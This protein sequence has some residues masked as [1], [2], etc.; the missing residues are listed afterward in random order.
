MQYILIVDKQSRLNP[1]NEKKSYVLN[2]EE[3]RTNGSVSDELIISPD[4][5]YVMRKLKLSEYQVL[6]VLENPI[7]EVIENPQIELFEGDNYIYLVDTVGN[8]FYAEYLIKND[9][10]DTF[11]TKREAKS[12][13]DMASN[14]VV[15]SVNEKLQSYSTTEEMNAAIEV[16]S[17]RINLEVSKKYN[18]SDFTSAK[19]IAEIN[20]GTSSVL[21]KADKVD[22]TGYV[23]VS[24]LS[25]GTTTIDGA[26]LTTGTINASKCTITNINASNI[27]TGT[28]DA[29]KIAVKNISASNITTGII[30]ASKITVTNINASNIITG[31]LDASKVTVKNL[32]ANNI[33]TG[34]IDANKITVKNIGASSIVLSANDV[35]N[36]LAGNEINLGSKSITIKSDNFVVDKSGNVTASNMN[37]SGGKIKII[38]GLSSSNTNLEVYNKDNSSTR[39]AVN[40]GVIYLDT[41]D[42]G[43]YINNTGI[44]S[45]YGAYLYNDNSDPQL[46]LFGNGTTRVKSSGITTPTV[47]QTSLEEIKKNFAKLDSV[48]HIIKNSEIYSYNMKEEK[49]TDKKHYGFVIGEKY[50]TPSEVISKSGQGI[51]TYSMSSIMWKAMQEQQELIENLQKEIEA[52]KK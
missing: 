7:K 12:Q 8:R 50:N 17:T 48:L 15:I 25:G 42:G 14:H 4:E 2:I 11:I 30:D 46:Y 22:L 29:T 40:A 9:F 24:G 43:L 16:A 39:S 5:S 41:N 52:I 26:C 27:T 21:I 31:T 18:A 49:D 51:D 32:D 33:T 19:I 1:S 23:T 20:G 3:L 47:S 37:I 35:L 6:S 28:I 44:S 36:I 34:T 38:G 13:I 10:N 45:N